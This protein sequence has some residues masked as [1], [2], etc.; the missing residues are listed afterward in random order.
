[1]VVV[2]RRHWIQEG[3]NYFFTVIYVVEAGGWVVTRW[4]SRL[5]PPPPPWA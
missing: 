1:M 3:F 4:N 5:T 2:N